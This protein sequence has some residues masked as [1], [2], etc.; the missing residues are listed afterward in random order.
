[1]PR[2]PMIDTCV[3]RLARRIDVEYNRNTCAA[4]TNDNNAANN[5][6]TCAPHTG[7]ARH[8]SPLR[9]VFYYGVPWRAATIASVARTINS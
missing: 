9:R 3:S 7:R 8:A 2:P 6:N 1:M 5:H 4:H